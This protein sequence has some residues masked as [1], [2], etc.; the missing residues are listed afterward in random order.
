MAT[1]KVSPLSLLLILFSWAILP[2]SIC[3]TQTE[4]QRMNVGYTTSS[5]PDVDIKDATAAL[6][7]WI[8]EVGDKEGFQTK[9]L[10]Y[11]NADALLGDFAAKKIDIA[12][13][14]TLEY[15]PAAKKI[16]SEIRQVS[17]KLGKGTVKYLLL[18]PSGPKYT[19]VRDLKSARFAVLKNNDLGMMFLN[20]QLVKAK[21]P[22]AKGFFSEIQEKAKQSQVLLSVFFGQAD[23]C[24]VTDTSY[25]TMTELNPQIVQKIKIIAASTELL[26]LVNFIQKSLDEA[27]KEKIV[28]GA[29]RAKETERGRQMLMLFNSDGVEKASD[30]QLE[31]AK[32]LVAEYESLK[33]K[34]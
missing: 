20:T 31:T 21:L 19:Q 5:L 23:A 1:N 3:H 12:F 11:E 32:Q 16:D 22:E 18:V 8:K 10:L 34:R 24:L 14:R 30:E 29:I 17:T 4:K 7:I 26:E 13:L 28:R 25:K 6:N 15:L 9:S 27:T 33:K 2:V